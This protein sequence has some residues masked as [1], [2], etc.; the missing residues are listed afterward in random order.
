[1]AKSAFRKEMEAGFKKHG[2]GAIDIGWVEQP[3]KMLELMSRFEPRN[4][5]YE[6]VSSSLT[7]EQ[8]A[9]MDEA[10]AWAAEARVPAARAALPAPQPGGI[11]IIGVTRSHAKETAHR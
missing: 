1:M 9:A 8:L 5:K 11:T 4:L 6:G 3:V 10:L 2:P 7:D